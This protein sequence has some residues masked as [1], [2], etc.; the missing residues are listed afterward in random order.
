MKPY[1]V[2]LFALA[3]FGSG[4]WVSPC[5][6]QYAPAR[7][8]SFLEESYNPKEANL[9]DL[10]IVELNQFVATFPD[11][12]LSGDAVYLLAKVY[13][14]KGKKPEALAA[15]YKAL[16]LYPEFNRRKECVA[17]AQEII[18]K[19]KDFQKKQDKL[20]NV[21]SGPLLKV[22]RADRY[23]AYLEFLMDFN[24]KELNEWTRDELRSFIAGY[25]A[26]S[27]LYTVLQWIADLNALADKNREAASDYK[28]LQVLY[29]DNPNLPYALYN[30]ARLMY[31]KLDQDKEAVEVCRS[32]FLS[33]P[34]NE[35]ACPAMFLF[36]EIKAKKLKD[37]PGAAD[38]YRKLLENYPNDKLAVDALLAVGN[39][40]REKMDNPTAAIAIYDEFI[41]K[42]RSSPRGV[43]ALQDAAE[44]YM[45]QLKDY[46]RA[47]EYYAQI[48]E[49]YPTFEKAP[50]MLLKAGALCEDKL[51]DYKKAI[52]YY[53]VILD[54]FADS[55]KA[56]DAKNKIEKAKTKI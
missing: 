10:L 32:L 54:K 52:S 2:C 44:I 25:P 56:N 36:A 39:L 4:A 41:A 18:A 33:Y 22:A 12:S 43:E 1:R 17:L 21:L 5:R 30:L 35:Y 24:E 26:D 34:Q 29:P 23:Y 14:D 55:K 46:S 16:Y 27:R 31:E 51:K 45:D 38:A 20:L 42:F 13:G 48:A 49:I 28:K 11:T 47:A 37:Y 40:N 19:E 6:A 7:L 3:I 15:L 9:R 8:L 53:Q 50:D